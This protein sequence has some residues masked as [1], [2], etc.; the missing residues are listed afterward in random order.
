[1]SSFWDIPIPQSVTMGVVLDNYRL[2]LTLRI[3][4]LRLLRKAAACIHKKLCYCTHTNERE[5]PYRWSF[6]ARTW[7]HDT[8]S[9]IQSNPTHSLSLQDSARIEQGRAARYDFFC[10]CDLWRLGLRLLYMW[11]HLIPY[12][13]YYRTNESLRYHHLHL[14]YGDYYQCT[15]LECRYGPVG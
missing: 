8:I 2:T 12:S 14:L 5:I 9:F 11:K 3:R 1:M 10:F 13:C 7:L 4:I 6:T 15:L